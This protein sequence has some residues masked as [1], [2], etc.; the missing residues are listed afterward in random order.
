MLSCASCVP[1]ASLLLLTWT[2]QPLGTDAL[3]SGSGCRVGSTVGAC[4]A[5]ALLWAQAGDTQG[6]FSPQ[7]EGR[8]HT[9]GMAGE[10]LP[11]GGVI[12]EGVCGVSCIYHISFSN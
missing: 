10:L 11:G 6:G 9:T 7:A 2:S 1:P 4:S 3:G 12:L 5:V 8:D